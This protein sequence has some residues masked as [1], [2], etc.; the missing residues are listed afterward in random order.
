M[1]RGSSTLRNM[2]YVSAEQPHDDV[3]AEH[4]DD[5]DDDDAAVVPIEYE[6]V[7]DAA[8]ALSEKSPP[9]MRYVDCHLTHLLQ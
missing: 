8:A 1:V 3:S 5:A 7:E 2:E 9:H 4:A 6:H